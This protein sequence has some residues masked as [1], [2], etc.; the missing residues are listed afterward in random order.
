MYTSAINFLLFAADNLSRIFMPNLVKDL[1]GSDMMLGI[2]V[3]AYSATMFLSHYIFGRAS[4]MHGRRLILRIGLIVSALAF[5]LQIAA[6]DYTSLLVARVIAGF[7]WGIAP[8]ALVA[9]VYETKKSIG[10]FS[11]YG[12]FGWF[13]GSLLAGLLV[14]YNRLFIVSSLF[15]FT[16]FLVSLRMPS[17]GEHKVSVPL[18]PIRIIKKNMRIYVQYFLRHLGANISWTVYPLYLSGIGASYFWIAITYAVNTGTQAIV[19]RYLDSYDNKKLISWGLFLSI[20]FFGGL[21]LATDFWKVIPLS[22][23][24]GFSWSMLYVGSLKTLLEGNV[25]RATATGLLNS[26]IHSAGILGPLMA[27][28]IATLAGYRAAVSVS[29]LLCFIAYIDNRLWKA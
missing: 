27:G 5:L 12:A 20:I 2:I 24:L 18:F 28:I 15:L 21:A 9:Y 3:A 13:I 7:A 25:E 17:A 22:V 16:G 11:S 14:A 4:D 29:A 8:A 26:T 19:M 6:W 1:G 10:K 23:I